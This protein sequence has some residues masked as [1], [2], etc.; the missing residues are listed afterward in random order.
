MSPDLLSLPPISRYKVESNG[1]E[2]F[3]TT[4]LPSYL[5]TPLLT[6][7]TMPSSKQPSYLLKNGTIISMDPNI[8]VLENG[9]ILTKGSYIGAVGKSLDIGDAPDVTVV[10][11]TDC[12]LFPGLV[13]AHH[14][15]W[16]Q[17]LRT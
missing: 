17:L 9:D 2:K 12:I 16:Q 11:A 7:F 15:M 10:D 5:H 4:L 3:M 13:D 8:G 14:H 6:Y 1:H